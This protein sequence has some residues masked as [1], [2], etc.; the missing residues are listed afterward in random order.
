[1]CIIVWYYHTPAFARVTV[2][3]VDLADCFSERP[4]M[5][6]TFSIW[7]KTLSSNRLG[8]FSF[9]THRP[10]GDQWY[11]TSSTVWSN[12][13]LVKSE[14]DPGVK[15]SSLVIFQRRWSRR[16][17]C[18]VDALLHGWH[19]KSTCSNKTNNSLCTEHPNRLIHIRFLRILSFSDWI[20]FAE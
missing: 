1:M 19:S 12:W 14:L 6:K 9:Q 20:K 17:D 8:F 5:G 13:V 2:Q 18:K 3:C 7:T 11:P 15:P 10:I 16:L 4:T